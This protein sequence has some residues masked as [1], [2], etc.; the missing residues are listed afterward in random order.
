MYQQPQLNLI[1]LKQYS[2][3]S[4]LQTTAT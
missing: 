4:K 1:T 2:T 3:S